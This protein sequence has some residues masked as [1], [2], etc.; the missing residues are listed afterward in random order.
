MTKRR[1]TPHVV[2]RKAVD[3]DSV[4]FHFNG[5]VNKIDM[6]GSDHATRMEVGSIIKRWMQTGFRGFPANA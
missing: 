5:H 3:E 6:A 1:Q 4:A 2:I